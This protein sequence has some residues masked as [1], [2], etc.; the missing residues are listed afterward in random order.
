MEK[1][2]VDMHVDDDQNIVKQMY[3][4]Y[5]QC[6]EAIAEL[7]KLGIPD[8]KIEDNITKIYDFVSDLNYCKKCPGLKKCNIKAEWLIDFFRLALN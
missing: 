6:N 8:D 1:I 4:E 5:L 7:K 3:R 2:K